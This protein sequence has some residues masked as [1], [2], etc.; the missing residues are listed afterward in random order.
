[1]SLTRF[2]NGIDTPFITGLA[3]SSSDDEVKDVGRKIFLNN[4]SVL[5]QGGVTGSDLFEGSVLEPMKTL[6]GAKGRCVANRGD[7]IYIMPN[8][9]ENIATAGAI[10]IDVDGVEIVCM[11]S[12][13]DRPT[14]T[15]T[16]AAGTMIVS[17]DNVSVRNMLCVPSIDAILSGFNVTGNGAD[18]DIEWAD[19]SASIEAE[20]AI[21]LDGSKNSKL[22]LKYSGF[23]A[24]NALVDAVRVDE[25]ENIDI[26]IDAY[27]VNSIAW[28]DMVDAAS[29]NVKVN[30]YMY[31][32]AIT[33]FDQDVLDTITGSTWFADFY[34]GSLGARVSGGSAAALASDDVTAVATDVAAILVDTAVIGAL[35]VGLTAITDDTT[36]IDSVTLAVAPIAGSLARF[37]A[38]GGTALGGQLPDSFS[39][40]DMQMGQKL[41]SAAADVLDGTQTALF[42]VA[43]G[44]V[45][46]MRLVGTVSGAAVDNAASDLNY[47]TNPTLGTDAAMCATLDIDLDENGTIYSCPLDGVTALDGGSGGGAAGAL[48]TYIVA[49]GTIDVLSTVDVG[50]GNAVLATELWW[51]P[52]DAG[53]TVVAI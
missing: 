12:G 24:G 39:L 29:I 43:G 41:T 48:S 30:G 51:R 7:T 22:K 25:C 52:I 50:T 53:A 26:E 21:R 33:T 27:G 20:C 8:H 4:S 16:A 6:N 19:A 37:L 2:P 10:D 34:D 5:P 35:G 1:M 28:V 3:L 38:S 49:A 18:I 42:T 13:D 32:E 31:T 14:F 9:A 44:K 47:V 40:I 23:T 46:I 15:F 17:G 11:G 45:E 36:K